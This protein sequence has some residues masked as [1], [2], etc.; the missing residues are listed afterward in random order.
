MARARSSPCHRPRVP[1]LPR[2]VPT[3]SSVRGASSV[4]GDR[5]RSPPSSRAGTT[6]VVVEHPLPSSPVPGSPIF[7]GS[8]RAFL[9]VVGLN[10]VLR[11]AVPWVRGDVS[12]DR[13]AT[14][15]C[16]ARGSRVSPK[17]ILSR[18]APSTPECRDV[19]RHVRGGWTGRFGPPRE[20]FRCPRF[21]SPAGKR[22]SRD[23]SSEL[24]RGP[25]WPPALSVGFQCA[26]GLW[27]RRALVPSPD[28][29]GVSC[30][31]GPQGP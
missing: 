8:S 18:P 12:P 29:D 6:T 27:V 31:R 26:S 20:P 4:F 1:R 7:I 30:R 9:A 3:P 21:S 2:P 14:V 13:P 19:L 5:R 17:I 11:A 15:G 23:A 22:V 16:G 10:L 24:C 25:G 28:A